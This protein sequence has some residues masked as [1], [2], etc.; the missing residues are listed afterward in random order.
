MDFA[1]S[2]RCNE[3]R[4]TLLEF[5]DDC[6]YPA[7]PQFRAQAASAENPWGT[8]PVLEELKAEARRRGLWNLFLPRTHE[9]GAGLTN[10]QYAPLAEITGRNPLIRIPLIVI[11]FTAVP[12]TVKIRFPGYVALPSTSA[13]SPG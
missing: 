2:D 11:L 4:A 6:V 5:M 10:T 12:G 1:F 7:E 13:T 3:Y 9:Y 8:P